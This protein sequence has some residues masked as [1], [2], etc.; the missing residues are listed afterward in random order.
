M[1]GPTFDEKM[2]A[3]IRRRLKSY[4]QRHD[5]GVPTL[6]MRVR[7][8]NPTAPEFTLKTLQRLLAN[9]NTSYD[10]LYN[11]CLVFLSSI[12]GEDPVTR[13]G[14]TAAA[15]FGT[16]PGQD[17][18]VGDP[19]PVRADLTGTYHVYAQGAVGEV[20]VPFPAD[21]DVTRRFD[22]PYSVMVISEVPGAPWRRV[23]EYVGN[24]RRH[25]GSRAAR[26]FT[27]VAETYTGSL[28]SLYRPGS[29]LVA[30]RGFLF[31]HPRFYLLTDS[32]I[33]RGS[34]PIL[35]GNFLDREPHEAA[36]SVF[37]AVRVLLRPQVA[38][39]RDQDKP[40]Q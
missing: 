38:A 1:I 21:I 22:V 4:Q 29:Y 32:N 18:M 26:A 17:E 8:A 30:L 15:L 31:N 40:S 2:R 13:L 39:D 37:A 27:H 36:E 35:D 6:W 34:P 5:I 23:E 19:I 10:H 12:Q 24:P 11:Q 20:G 16:P 25:I 7:D 33:A 14:E 28:T 3:E 9:T